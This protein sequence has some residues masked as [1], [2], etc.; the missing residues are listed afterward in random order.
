ML[1]FM[2]LLAWTEFDLNWNNFT[3]AIREQRGGI[4]SAEIWV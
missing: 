2:A 1:N 3:S 4:V